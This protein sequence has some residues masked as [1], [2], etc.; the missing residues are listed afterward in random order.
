MTASRDGRARARD[1]TSAR[2]AFHSARSPAM[3]SGGCQNPDWREMERDD[4][5]RFDHI[6]DGA[7][8]QKIVRQRIAGRIHAFSAA[9]LL[10]QKP[11]RAVYQVLI[12]LA[13]PDTSRQRDFSELAGHSGA[14]AED[15]SDDP[16]GQRQYVSLHSHGVTFT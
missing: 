12:E 13:A 6:P 2:M 10:D 11:K 8:G 15:R 9:K 5:E 1:V 14:E 16:L 4:P 3:S 7:A